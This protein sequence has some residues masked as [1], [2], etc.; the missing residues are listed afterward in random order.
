MRR[1][2]EI[3]KQQRSG[4]L[5]PLLIYVKK[6]VLFFLEIFI[7]YSSKRGSDEGTYNEYP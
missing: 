1:K 6:Q 3:L 2:Q 7:Y 5:R 4:L